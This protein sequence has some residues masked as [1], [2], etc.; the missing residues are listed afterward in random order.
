[1]KESLN[2]NNED[3]DIKSEDINKEQA[4][5]NTNS[6]KTLEQRILEDIDNYDE[7]D[8]SEEKPAPEIIPELKK[9][10]D[11]KSEESSNEAVSRKSL[12]N[13]SNY[14]I[15]LINENLLR[16][17]VTT[18][19]GVNIDCSVKDSKS[20]SETQSNRLHLH[21]KP[22]DEPQEV[23]I[24][25]SIDPGSGELIIEKKK[26]NSG[27]AV[28]PAFT[29]NSEVASL[30]QPMDL[31][32]PDE[33]IIPMTEDEMLE[34][35]IG[36][37]NP[38]HL[39]RLLYRKNM[40]TG[41]ISSVVLSC[42]LVFLFYNFVGKKEK[43]FIQPERRLVVINDIPAKIN[44]KEYEDPNKPKEEPKTETTADKT[45]PPTITR[46]IIK[47]PRINRPP[48]NTA[49]DSNLTKDATKELDS[50]RKLAAQDSLNKSD[51]LN[52]ANNNSGNLSD[53]LKKSFSENDLGLQVAYPEGWKD[54]DMRNIDKSQEKFK[55]IILT[56][57]TTKEN[58]AVNVFIATDNEGKEY[59]ASEFKTNFAMND[60]TA[61]AY[62]NEP[63]TIAGAT[64]LRFYIFFKTDKLSIS[65]Q[66]K[67]QYFDQYRPIV[68]AIIRTIRINPPQ[69][70]PK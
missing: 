66:I 43:E 47:A 68:E 31:G 52:T 62:V 39:N 27:N 22:T 11:S 19:K 63:R 38:F 17:R 56:D 54:I 13:E 51:S 10:E 36:R 24:I 40:I 9:E 29:P 28:T 15:N 4:E 21:P 14:Q 2:E 7:S 60:S 46:N 59:N 64:T 67:K 1:M 42:I 44:F 35:K 25:I 55:G 5:E 33:P 49:K 48:I 3:K 8:G 30:I 26:D 23:E 58:G 45:A 16:I 65:A 32:R 41:I 69:E 57:T 50:L 34:L 53:S 12:P 70:T 18:R 20:S 6:E 61:T 37:K